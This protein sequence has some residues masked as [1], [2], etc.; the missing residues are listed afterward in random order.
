MAV[1]TSKWLHTYA[2]D[3]VATGIDRVPIILP[4]WDC[5]VVGLPKKLFDRS[6]I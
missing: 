1:P 4:K 5:W 6:A 3:Y 2:L